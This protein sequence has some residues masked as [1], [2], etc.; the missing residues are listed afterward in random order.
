MPYKICPYCGKTS[1]SAAESPSIE[2]LCPYC[3]KDISHAESLTSVPRK[4][5]EDEEK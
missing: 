4:E 1:Y 3:G 2:W 5:K